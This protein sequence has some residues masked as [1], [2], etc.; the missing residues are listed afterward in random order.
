MGRNTRKLEY[1]HI[2]DSGDIVWMNFD[3]GQGHEQKGRRPAL[4]LTSKSFNLLTGFAL[5][6]PMTSKLKEYVFHVPV[7]INDLRG[8]IMIDQIKSVSWRERNIK[9]Y[10]KLDPIIFDEIK[11][12]IIAMID[13]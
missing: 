4:I 8:S 12:K 6:C 13:Y 11:G 5:I 7:K 10:Q 3:N 9:F 1:A 2:P